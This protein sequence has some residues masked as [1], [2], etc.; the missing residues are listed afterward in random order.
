MFMY[1][2]YHRS[3]TNVS[4]SVIYFGCY[5]WNVYA[6]NADG[7]LKWTFDTGGEIELASPVVDRSGV[8]YIGS[9]NELLNALNSDGTLKW[10][11]D[12][13]GVVRRSAAVDLTNGIIY[14]GSDAFYIFAI[15]PDG[16]EKWRYRT[17]GEVSSSVTLYNANIYVCDIEGFMYCLAPDATLICRYYA[18]DMIDVST[19]AIDDYGVIYVGCIDD[20]L[21]AINPDCTLKWIFTTKGVIT[22]TPSIDTSGNIY[23]G[24]YDGHLYSVSPD[25]KLRWY[26]D[27]GNIIHGSAA[28]SD[29]IYFGDVFGFLYALYFF[30]KPEW[31]Y[32]TGN[33]I[34][35]TPAIDKD[36]VIFI[37]NRGFKMYAF[38]PDGTVKWIFVAGEGIDSSAAV[39]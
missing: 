25:G 26:F 2:R 29:G 19:P 28:L 39:V 3:V 17:T 33:S 10:K 22:S 21:H 27:T 36:G 15:Y 7:T 8:I 14:V 24:S 32:D 1:D 13:E 37:G 23:F 18:G 34:Y 9:M 5:D 31:I 6:L 16:R 38:N 30:G 20:N 12:A 11:F 35:T 4:A